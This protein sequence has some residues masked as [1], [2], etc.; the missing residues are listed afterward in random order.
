MTAD[1]VAL[2]ID[3]KSGM[4]LK[5]QARK[6]PRIG[7]TVPPSAQAPGLEP[8]MADPASAMVTG[9]TQRARVEKVNDILSIIRSTG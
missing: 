7:T 1:A 8:G 2:L 5:S 9:T 3:A 4:G 6:M